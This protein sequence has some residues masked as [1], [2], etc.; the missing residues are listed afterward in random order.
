MMRAIFTAAIA[1]L[2]SA[3]IASEPPVTIFS[4]CECRNNHG[5]D[6]PNNSA[7]SSVTRRC[8]AWL[9]S[10]LRLLFTRASEQDDTKKEGMMNGT[11]GFRQ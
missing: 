11:A 2:Y 10:F 9:G 7:K 5:K 3:A 1:L 4:P 8:T 6:L